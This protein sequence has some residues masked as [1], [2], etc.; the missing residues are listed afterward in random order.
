MTDSSTRL[1]KFAYGLDEVSE[2]IGLGRSTLYLEVRAG[3]LRLAKV[4]KTSIVLAEDLAE[5]I[6][7]LRAGK[8]AGRTIA[9]P[10]KAAEP[11]AG[12]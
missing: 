10:N 6:A 2:L 3:R 7:G 9:V 8:S 11:E 1:T 12:Q 4:G 5:F